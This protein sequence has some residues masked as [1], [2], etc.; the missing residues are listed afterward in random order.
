MHRSRGFQQEMRVLPYFVPRVEREPDSA[1]E[2]P[3]SRPYFLFVGRL[4]KIKGVQEILHHF[5]GPGD[6]D[7]VVVGGGLYQRQLH[8]QAAGMPRVRFVG[9]L[10]PS[11][12]G[13]YYRHAVA[14]VVPSVT[15]E[16]F[17]I[18]I[19]EAFSHRTP[20]IVHDLGS[21][22]EIV[23]QS[24]AGFIYR[25]Q[26]ELRQQMDRLAADPQTPPGTR[27]A[28]VPGTHREM[29]PRTAPALVSATHRKRFA[30]RNWRV[31]RGLPCGS[32]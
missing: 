19:I 14:V 21:L 29:D 6:Y 8:E 27:R 11:D 18:I 28:R 22:P 25:S 7:L 16:T 5:Q 10:N 32:A 3:H 15:Y 23:E 12:V 2:S 26:D 13:R 20:A 17:G 30:A 1:G 9:W 31:K 24:G 4:E